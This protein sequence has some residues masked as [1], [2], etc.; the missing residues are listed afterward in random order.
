MQTPQKPASR[1]WRARIGRRLRF[2][3]R[4]LHSASFMRFG[5]PASGGIGSSYRQEVD[6]EHTMVKRTIRQLESKVHLSGMANLGCSAGCS[7]R[8][9]LRS[10]SF[11]VVIFLVSNLVLAW[12]T[13]GFA[14]L[15]GLGR[16]AETAS[17]V[18]LSAEFTAPG[19]GRQSFL[20]IHARIQPG[21]Y[22]YSLTQ[23]PGGPRATRI[24]VDESPEFRLAGDFQANP[25]PATKREPLFDNLLVEYHAGEVTWF[26]P[27]EWKSDVDLSQVAI[28]GSV[29]AQVCDEATCYPPQS[30]SFT[31]RLG[32]G[33][34][35]PDLPPTAPAAVSRP[36]EAVVPVRTA[37]EVSLAVWLAILLGA[38][39]GGLILNL[40]PCVLPVISLK[41]FALIEQAG[42]SRQKI[43]MLN[44]WFTLGLMSVFLVLATFSAAFNLAWGE[45]FTYT[46]F[47]V[48][49]IGLV[50]TLAL[51][52]LG[53]WELPI[54]G[55]AGS[56][57]VGQLQSQ[58]GAT[59]AFF[60][61]VFTT[62]LATP[63]TGPFLGTVFGFTLDKPPY[64][65]YLIFGT[66]GL[67]MA[68]P[69]ILVGIFPQLIRFL[70]RPGQWMNT[71]KEIM[72]FFLLGTVVYLFSTIKADYFIPTLTFVVGLWLACWL[73]GKVPLTAARR[74]RAVAWLGAVVIAVGTGSFAYTMLVPSQK[75]PWEPFSPER[76]E[77]ALR[78]GRT[79][80]V[81]FTAD[82]CPNCKWNL[83]TAIE[84]TRV[85]RLVAEYRVL[86]LLADWTDE[87]P[88]IK[89]FLTQRLRRRSIPVLAIYPA[90]GREEDVIILD[91]ILVESQVL[92]ALRKAGPS[93][94][95]SS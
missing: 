66:V 87:S 24:R 28:T 15:T 90:G 80:M 26:A 70:P 78:E 49:L 64:V 55:F 85:A 68:F 51:S 2:R 61:G 23:P 52:F 72:G 94:I 16:G 93:K 12:G 91:G 69:Y 9:T 30:F 8:A 20:V 88:V 92:E 40:M 41:L 48:A 65:S 44:L 79:V 89:D 13:R 37:E 7:G 14:Q 4:D 54:P 84:T 74:Q 43:F 42:Q 56:S 21:H 17:H 82:W 59:G 76:L 63:C 95:P 33:K 60:K 32:E 31:A 11:L 47:K 1:I 58:E 71:L 38:F 75:I 67:G 10:V 34:L 6:G 19:E 62:I 81:D 45:Q 53:V 50:F 77:A 73:V 29:Q 3:P 35:L 39:A 57:R 18:Q 22:I 5:E 86:P 25:P 83:A 27:I 46:W 36:A